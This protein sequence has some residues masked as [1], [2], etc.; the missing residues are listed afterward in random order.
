MEVWQT[1]N[2]RRLRL[3]EGKKKNK[4]QHENILVCPKMAT[5]KVL[6]TS[7]NYSPDTDTGG[8]D[9]EMDVRLG[10]CLMV[11]VADSMQATFKHR[12]IITNECRPMPNVMAALS[13]MGSALCS[14]PQSLPDAHY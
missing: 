11:L 4:L 13:N 14:T 2:L 6:L 7:R 3:G 12:I 9:K 8:C 10:N 5:I 1:S